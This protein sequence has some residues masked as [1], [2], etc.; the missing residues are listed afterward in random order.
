MCED[1]YSLL[2]CW[3][4]S[5]LLLL[6]LLLLQLGCHQVAGRRTLDGRSQ[7]LGG[8]SQDLLSRN[9]ALRFLRST[10]TEGHL[11]KSQHLQVLWN[12]G[13][14]KIPLQSLM[15]INERLSTVN[16]QKS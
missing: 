13:I 12:S 1:V 10:V 16:R 9:T 15:S 7:D 6:L 4:Q 11:H 2:P 14:K 8:R 3:T 5:N